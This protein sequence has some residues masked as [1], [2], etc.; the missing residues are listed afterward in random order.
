MIKR[1]FDIIFSTIGL[2]ALVPL[3][4]LLGI[5]IRSTGKP[6][7]F[8]QERVGRNGK[9]FRICKFRSM[10][11]DAEKI[12]AQV[13]SDRD[14]RITRIG[15]WLRRTKLDEL[16]QLI[17]VFLGNMSIVGPRP[18][19]PY[20]VSL[21]PATDRDFIL[22][23]KPG[24]TDIGTLFYHNEQALL[25]QAE[26]PESFYVDEVMPHKLEMYKSYV[27]GRGFWFDL[28]IILATFRRLLAI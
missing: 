28:K 5:I 24:I 9:V 21:W 25:A 8:R 23:V 15:R 20:Y 13:T 1:L 10:V 19:V 26:E 7:F 2:V 11:V 14:P 3:F 12:G 4:L 27:T 6:I 18:E 22:S 17:N 16:P